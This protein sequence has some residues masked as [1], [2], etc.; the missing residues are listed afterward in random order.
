MEDVASA[1]Y[2]PIFFLHHCNIDRLFEKYLRLYPDC[3]KQFMQR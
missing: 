3:E 2:D 1:S